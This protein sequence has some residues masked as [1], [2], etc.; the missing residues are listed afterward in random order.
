[1]HILIDIGGTNIRITKSDDLE[2]FND[3]LIIKT[4]L[5]YAEGIQALSNA[6][7]TVAAGTVVQSIVVGIRGSVS[8]EKGTTHDIGAIKD[9]SGK[10]IVAELKSAGGTSSVFLENDTALVGLGEATYG[11]GVD[12]GI[13]AY[14]TV[15]TGVN[16]V[17]IVDGRV[18][19]TAQ[20]FE[21]GG[22]YIQGDTKYSLEEIISGAAIEKKYGKHP[23]ELGAD[24]P[25]WE[26]LARMLGVG[27][28]NTLLHWSPNRVVLGG[29]M[30][31]EIG[32]KVDKVSQHVREIM[33]KFPTTPEIVHAKLGDLG[34]LWGGL[35]RLKQLS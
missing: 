19:K 8:Q 24:S 26:E 34:G 29:S 6:V 31:N 12:A 15:S 13:V 20:G 14:V 33:K 35:A 16:G 17:R 10:P 3:P 32:I 27:L 23:R 22:Q 21:I 9:W 2:R 18:D 25:V 5:P 30:F 1:M 28:H 11:A 7:R 4:P